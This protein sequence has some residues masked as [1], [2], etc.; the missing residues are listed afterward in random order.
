M[1]EQDEKKK[2]VEWLKTVIGK[3]STCGLGKFERLQEQSWIHTSDQN[4]K[5]SLEILVLKG[6]GGGA[7]SGVCRL[8]LKVCY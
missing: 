4:A 2:N 1:R 7:G 3:K 8:I 5:C 6:T